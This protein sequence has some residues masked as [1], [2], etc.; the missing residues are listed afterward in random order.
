MTSSTRRRLGKGL[1]ALLPS[2][3]AQEGESVQAVP[4]DAIQ[5]NPHQPRRR[6]DPE[7]IQELAAS[8]REHGVVQPVIL[9]KH[10]T[11]YQ[12]VAG[13]RRWRAAREAGLEKI[14]AVVRSLSEREMMEIALIENLQREDLN[15]LEEAMAYRSALER[16]QLNQE[17]LARRLG[18]SRSL[19][20]NTLRL[21]NL[22]GEVQDLLAGGRLSAGHCRAMLGLPDAVQVVLARRIVEEGLNVRQVEEWVRRQ[23]EGGEDTARRSA[24][25]SETQALDPDVKRAADRLADRLG[26]RV[27]IRTRRKKGVIEIEFYG[28]EDLERLIQDLVGED[29]LPV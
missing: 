25:K 23:R 8:I 17:E 21:L 4:L 26:T 1:D 5:P 16:L 13:E 6:I 22:P 11:G 2:L 14:P 7:K 12:L 10:D 3:E 20:A 15:P 27:Q 24:K 18:K 28:P 19:V 9:R 29:G